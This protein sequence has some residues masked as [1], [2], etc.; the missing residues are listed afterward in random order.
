MATEKKGDFDNYKE[1]ALTRP[2]ETAWENWAKFEK[3]GDKVSGYIRDVFYRKAEGE[4]KEQRGIT[5]EQVD[6]E[7]INVAVKRLPFILEK[8]DNLRLGD[9][10]TIEFEKTLA[11]RQKG[12]KGT[13]Q[14][15]FYGKNLEANASNKTVAELDR[16]DMQRQNAVAPAPEDDSDPFAEPEA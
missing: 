1:N 11:P 9:P 8:T 5:L 7:L 2:Y 4:F 15:G 10:L 14:Y 13:K 3:E 16:E 6:G 12:Y